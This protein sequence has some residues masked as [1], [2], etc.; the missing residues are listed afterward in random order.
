MNTGYHT[1]ISLYKRMLDITRKEQLEIAQYQ[2][3]G[4]ELC[5]AEKEKLIEEIEKQNNG[6][7]WVSCR[8]QS[9]EILSVIK[10]IA[11]LNQINADTL[12]IMKDSLLKDV[13]SLHNSQKAVKAYRPI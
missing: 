6:E 9:D 10:K 12:R 4:I 7:S 11:A 8:E 1:M 3:G 13:S 5:W 2:I